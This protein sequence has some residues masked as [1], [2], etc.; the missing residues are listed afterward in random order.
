MWA[1]D[2]TLSVKLVRERMVKGKRIRARG[3]SFTRPLGRET[4]KG[5]LLVMMREMEKPLVI[6]RSHV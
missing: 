4:S 2:V 6:S 5:P 1:W 3:W